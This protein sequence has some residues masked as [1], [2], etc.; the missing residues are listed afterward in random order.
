MLLAI[1]AG[2]AAGSVTRY[3]ISMWMMRASGAFPVATLT[4]NI[5]GAFLLGFLARA[6][7]TPDANPVLR[8][9]LTIGFCGGFTTFS[10]FSAEFVML[11]QEGR[12]GRAVAYAL[13]SVITG[14]LAVVA[15]MALGDRVLSARS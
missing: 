3:L 1:A 6:L 14:V 11:V 7:S 4:V 10:T 12:S 2:G 5:V 9:A 15:G 8:A 13:V